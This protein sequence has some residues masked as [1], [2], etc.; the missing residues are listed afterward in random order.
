MRIQ[1]YAAK[2]EVRI[3]L[4]EVRKRKLQVGKSI[5]NCKGLRRSKGKK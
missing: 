2:V 5:E 4:R 3:W 1:G